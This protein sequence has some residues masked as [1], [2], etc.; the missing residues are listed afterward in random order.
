M[1]SARRTIAV[2]LHDIEPATFERCALIRDWLDDHGV[3]RV[4]LLV[5][6]ARDLHPFA[7]RSPELVEWLIER[8][9]AGD[10]IAQHG[11]QHLRPQ[12][13]RGR[14]GGAYQSL[15]TIGADRE[16][17]FVG[18]DAHET[19]RAVDAGRRVLKL[20]G[21]EPRGFV[22][23]GYAYTPALRQT[24]SERF[25]WW[26]ALMGLHRTQPPSIELSD[27]ASKAWT[28]TWPRRQS[29]SSARRRELLGPPIALSSGGRLRRAL[30]PT[31]LRTG[32]LLS[33]GTLRLDLHPSDLDRANHMLAL[34]WVLG[35]AASG[36]E[37]VTYEQLAN[38]GE[39]APATE[40]ALLGTT[41][42][43]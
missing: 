6:P 11:F 1:S 23:P 32:A 13:A 42:V 24:L 9:R 5:I 29:H 4:T 22:A 37:A 16:N 43:Q 39:P 3:G 36:R 15:R 27:G 20:A 18:L 28:P 21:I 7:E 12:R 10:A 38:A 17:E 26:A 25:Q 34:E 30:S 40:S 41:L 35:H 14:S 2:A 19:R 31:L 8:E 33:G